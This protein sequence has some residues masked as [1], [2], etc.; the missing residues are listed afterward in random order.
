MKKPH[1]L[2]WEI[3]TLLA[4]AV[5]TEEANAAGA[6]VEVGDIDKALVVLD[7]TASA[8]DA[9]DTLD[10]YV[11]VSW[12]GGT[13]WFNAIHFAQQAG[14]GAAKKELAV[15]SSEVNA[16]DPDAVL[17][18]TGDAAA[19][20]IRQPLLGPLMR[21]RSTVVRLTGTDESHTF[22]VKAYVK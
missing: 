6:S 19:G 5:H 15:L 18:I 4:S 9:G 10:V 14:N 21:V 12:D 7:V 16:T 8:T 20:V 3:L 2:N 13:S 17:A 1:G 22:S 11:D